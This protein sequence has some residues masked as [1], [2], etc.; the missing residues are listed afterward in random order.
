VN[1]I[2]PG[3][4]PAGPRSTHSWQRLKPAWVKLFTNKPR[5]QAVPKS[6]LDDTNTL[7]LRASA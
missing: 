7:R 5:N 2:Y 4:P 3:L 6:V 1:F